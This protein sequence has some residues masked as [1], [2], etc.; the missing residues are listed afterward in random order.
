MRVPDS[1]LIRV[2]HLATPECL[3]TSPPLEKIAAWSDFLKQPVGFRRQP[4][5]SS[6]KSNTHGCLHRRWLLCR[7]CGALGWLPPAE[8]EPT[9]AADRLGM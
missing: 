7:E 5:A 3:G 1:E 6:G 4:A 9:A 8:A 2:V